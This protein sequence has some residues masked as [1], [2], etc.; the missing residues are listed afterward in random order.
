M[1]EQKKRLDWANV[2]KA[3]AYARRIWPLLKPQWPQ[4]LLV[5]LGMVL[6]ASGYAA[7]V[8]VIGLFMS[9]FDPR[10]LGALSD[11]KAETVLRKVAPSAGL[12]F[13]GALAMAVGTFLK[14]YYQGYLRSSTIRNL[15]RD[16]VARVLKQP[17]A[18]FNSER[19]GALMSR[20]TTN[21]RSAG[22]LV[23]IMLDVVLAQPLTMIG[24][25]AV[26]FVAD[27]LLTLLT[28]V[29]LPIVLV[30]VLLFAGKIRK[31]TQN[32]YKKLEASGNFFHQ[33][34]DGIRVVKG[35]RLEDAQR[36]EFNRVSQ[37]VFSR[38]RKVARYKGT[39]RFGVEFTYNTLLA[40]GL[41]AVGYM[42][43]TPWFA[44]AG[45]L[46]LLVMFFAGLVFLYDPARKLGHS[47]NDIQESTAGLDRVFELMDRVPEVQDKSDA[48]EA[49][50][51]F[52]TIEFDHLGFEYIEDRPVLRDID[53]TVKRGEMI[54]LVGQSGQGKSTLMDL[55]PRFYDPTDGAIRVDGT[56]LRDF[57]LE[58]WLRNIAIVSQDTFLFNTTVRDNIRAGRPEATEEQIIEAARAAH[59]WAEIQ[60]MPKGLDTRLGDRGVTISGGQ[61]QRIAIARAFLRKSPILL[62][63]EATSSLD[64]ESE[65]EVQKALDELIEECTVFAVAHRLSTV[66]NADLILV[67]NEGRIIER[68][69]HEQLIALDGAYANAYRLQH[70]QEAQAA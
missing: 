24:V 36:D 6:F 66:R 57:K 20:M 19:K 10:D 13:V 16:I 38:E 69:T 53:L 47:F 17:M 41:F 70:G 28:F 32:K 50:H 44:E 68:G 4:L 25:V 60:D 55:I 48:A 9:E 67:L 14:Q 8:G 23:Q 34:L 2:R 61:R 7:R 51:D 27:P 5:I 31:A 11:E 22:Q 35:Y 49:P 45:R 37:E 56:D 62:L 42:M 65:R 26:L 29:V 39:S 46:P 43:T 33:M 63:D 54:A 30:P 3:T 64:T 12:L 58:S 21:A 40:L 52:E 59:I 1:A 15:Q 18:F